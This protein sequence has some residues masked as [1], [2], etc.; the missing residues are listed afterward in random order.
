MTYDGP[1]EG[2][3]VHGIHFTISKAVLEQ[4][5]KLSGRADENLRGLL[6]SARPTGESDGYSSSTGK[7]QVSMSFQDIDSIINRI[8]QP[9][10]TKD[11]TC[12]SIEK[13]WR[14]C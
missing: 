14:T 6:S 9:C 4:L 2:I 10:K 11:L 7:D 13:C 5:D 8:E 1:D 12:E 3:S